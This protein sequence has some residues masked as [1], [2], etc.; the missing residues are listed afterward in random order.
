M[1]FSFFM[2]NLFCF[3]CIFLRE[4][5]LLFVFGGRKGSAGCELELYCFEESA[6][7]NG[8][9]KVVCGRMSVVCW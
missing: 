1:R 5:F 2:R 9:R 6:S 8:L 3:F 4:T 7:V